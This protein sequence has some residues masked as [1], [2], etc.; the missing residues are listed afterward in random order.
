MAGVFGQRDIQSGNSDYNQLAFTIRQFLNKINTATLVRVVAVHGG[1]IGPVGTVDVL[2][3]VNQVAGD[4]TPI[5]HVTV[6]GLP[7]FRLQGGVAAIICDPQPGDIGYCVFADHDISGVKAQGGQASPPTKRRFDFSDGLYLG[8]WDSQITPTRYIQL[9]LNSI[10][11]NAED[12][13]IYASDIFRLIAPQIAIDGPVVVTGLITGTCTL[14][15]SIVGVGGVPVS[16]STIYSESNPPPVN[17]TNIMLGATFATNQAFKLISGGIAMP[18]YS[19]D[20]EMP[21]VDGIVLESGINGAVVPV[22]MVAGGEYT[23]PLV[24]PAGRFLFLGQDGKPTATIPS[25]IAGDVWSI[26][27]IE[28]VD[29]THF[30]LLART[31]LQLA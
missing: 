18:I 1:G 30:I 23:T 5:P 26:P 11:I 20:N 17:I 14:A 29:S 21:T 3:L 4:G 9:G 27:I 12:V 2:P 6:F 31:P 8:G 15:E 24:L 19:T 7:F 13:Y 25:I 22:A 16:G 10:T 28:Q